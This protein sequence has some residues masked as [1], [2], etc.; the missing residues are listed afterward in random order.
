L[1]VSIAEAMRIRTN[2]P[3]WAHPYHWWGTPW[4]KTSDP[5]LPELVAEGW[6]S[7][8]A[9]ES[10][11]AVVTRGASIVVLGAASGAGK[12]RLLWAVAKELSASRARVYWRGLHESLDFLE[13]TEPG[14]TTILVNEISPHLPVYA[15]GPLVG[16]LA[17]CAGHGC[18]ILATG[19]AGTVM[20][21]LE[22]IGRP[23]LCIPQEARGFMAVAAVIE[24]SGVRI[25]PITPLGVVMLEGLDPTGSVGA[26][27]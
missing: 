7:A 23:E 12:S 20:E 3:P 19:H 16:Q 9:A 26:R 27:S 1:T 22:L 10:L 17:R 4:A 13:A 2:A 8:E 5:E 25:E 6:L 14:L 21:W 24:P 18:Q 11:A 15:W